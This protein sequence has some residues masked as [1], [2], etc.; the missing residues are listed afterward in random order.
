M[1]LS[2]PIATP[3]LVLTP[4]TGDDGDALYLMESDPAVKRFTGGTLTRA[5]TAQ[6][7]QGFITQ[8]AATG[9]GAIAIK[10]KSSGELIGLCGLV[11]EEHVGE[12]FYGLARRAWGQGFGVETCQ[13][14]IQAGFQQLALTRIIATVDPANERSIRLLERLGMRLVHGDVAAAPTAELVYELVAPT[15]SSIT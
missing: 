4:F 7:L 6:L 8:V 10:T 13:G 2:Y 3:R 14:L 15:T 1:G 5:E 12:I 11:V 9:L